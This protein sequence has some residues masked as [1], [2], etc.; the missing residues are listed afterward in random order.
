MSY[1]PNFRGSSAKASRK[2]E[3]NYTNAAGSTLP[4]GSV[5]S[6]NASGQMVLID[7]T[8]GTSVDRFLGITSASTP[9]AA[10]GG[11]VR[12]GRIEEFTTGFAVGD[13]LYVNSDGTLTN[14]KPDYGVGDFAEGYF[15]IFIGVVVK[16]EFNLSLKDLQISPMVVGQL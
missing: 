3:S 4:M 8:D 11:V 16:N 9:D 2:V 15:V 14:V 12:V 6:A 13:A 7:I 1:N 10:S 5:V